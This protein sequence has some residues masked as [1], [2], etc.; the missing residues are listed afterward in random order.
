VNWDVEVCADTRMAG[1]HDRDVRKLS[2]TDPRVGRKTCDAFA[3]D[4]NDTR[5]DDNV[6]PWDLSPV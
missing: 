1:D 6:L 2:V 4:R 5:R 3:I